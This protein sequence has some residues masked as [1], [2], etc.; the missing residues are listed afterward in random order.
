MFSDMFSET[1]VWMSPMV[2]TLLVLFFG[3]EAFV[4]N[5]SAGILLFHPCFQLIY[6]LFVLTFLK[7]INK[8]NLKMLG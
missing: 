8:A 3:F 1:E 4:F 6:E 7:N 2:T 5:L